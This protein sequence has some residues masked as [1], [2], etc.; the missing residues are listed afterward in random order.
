MEG[1]G[2]SA[3]L[4]R[5]VARFVRRFV[6][7][8]D[9]QLTALA[10]WVAHTHAFEAADA[11]PYLAVTSAE[12][13]S[14]KSRLLEV[15]RLLVHEPLP[16]ANISDAAL[17]R[18]VDQQQPTLLFD[19]IDAVFRARDREELRGLL[20]AGYCRGA[21]AYRI[22]GANNRDLQSFRV[23][24]AKVFAGI[25]DCLPDTIVDRSV[26]IRLARRL[27]DEPIERFRRRETAADG[28]LL[29]RDALADWLEPQ[30]EH[31]AALRPELPDELDD[32]AQDVWE[33]LFAIADLAGDE[34]PQR[35]W[36][37]ALALSTGDERDDDSNTATLIR[38]VVGVFES[39]GTERLK[40]ADLLEGLHA[41]PD[42]PWAEWYGKPL[43]ST[44]LSKLLKAYR[45]KTLPVWV[46]GVT[47]RGYK[48]EQFADAA[49]RLGVRSVRNV[50]NDSAS[51]EPPNA[52]NAPNAGT[53][54]ENGAAAEIEKLRRAEADGH[55][56][57]CE[58][59]EREG[60]LLA[61]WHREAA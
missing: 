46:D 10:L 34:W 14:G 11:T 55:V 38:D 44:G 27:P 47:V 28:E 35:A 15:L 16:T 61:W 17:F 13:R 26:P 49:S 42:S 2:M 18:A 1:G 53:R 25:G 5:D 22:G 37:A 36:R 52:P 60:L 58:R 48:L 33:P 6:V 50:R 20:N 8:D 43:T 57:R 23:F 3:A 29:I 4:L 59:L 41:V 31:L 12:K 19:E 40:T 32:R 39:R 9:D 30:I 24:C 54:D 45:I 51:G 21:V 7:L 56:T